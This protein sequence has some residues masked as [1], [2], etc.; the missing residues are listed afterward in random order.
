MRPSPDV[1]EQ[2]GSPLNMQK[3]NIRVMQASTASTKPLQE[4]APSRD[5][6]D[7]QGAPN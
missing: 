4:S 5:Q 7:V 2:Q 3:A 6:L 1:G